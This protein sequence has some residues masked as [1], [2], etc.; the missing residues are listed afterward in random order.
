MFFPPC[1]VV[2]VVHFLK[3]LC[4]QNSA[5]DMSRHRFTASVR[6]TARQ[7]HCSEIIMTNLRI[8][9]DHGG[10]HIHSLPTASELQK[11]RRRFVSQSARPEM[12]AHTEEILLVGKTIDTP[13]SGA[14]PAE[15]R[16]RHRIQP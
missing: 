1:E 13:T 4:A 3:N 5:S 6:V 7:M 16:L 11:M 2:M 8:F 14:A 15:V 9:I 12:H 10:R